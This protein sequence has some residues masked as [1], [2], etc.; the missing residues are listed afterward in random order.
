MTENTMEKV[1]KVNP[2][3]ANAKLQIPVGLNAGFVNIGAVLKSVINTI[4]CSL[5]NAI[6]D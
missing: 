1:L 6:N 3:W 5:Q 2:L 4:N